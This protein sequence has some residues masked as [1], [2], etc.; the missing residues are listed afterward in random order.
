MDSLPQL[1][2]IPIVTFYVGQRFNLCSDI[3]IRL[4]FRSSKITLGCQSLLSDIELLSC[5]R[6]MRDTTLERRRLRFPGFV[7]MYVFNVLLTHFKS[8]CFWLRLPR[9][10]CYARVSWVFLFLTIPGSPWAGKAGVEVTAMAEVRGCPW[11]VCRV[12]CNKK[13]SAW[14]WGTSPS[15]PGFLP[16]DILS[17]R[18]LW[19]GGLS[20]AY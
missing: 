19:C 5:A 6:I 14:G 17:Q 4:K 20:W 15:L 8:E 7:N 18:I 11:M 9:D 3:W 12:L 13:M 16:L 2:R 1:A 10:W